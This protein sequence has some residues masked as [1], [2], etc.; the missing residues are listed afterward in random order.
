VTGP[1]SKADL[2]GITLGGHK[3]A[4]ASGRFAADKHST[5]LR[6]NLFVVV[7]TD[8]QTDRCHG[9]RHPDIHSPTE[10]QTDKQTDS[11]PNRQTDRCFDRWTDR[12]A[13]NLLFCLTEEETFLH[14]VYTSWTCNRWSATAA[15]ARTCCATGSASTKLAWCCWM[16]EVSSSAA[17]KAGCVVSRFRNSW[18]VGSPL[19][20]DT[21]CLS[22]S[23]A[24][25]ECET[26]SDTPD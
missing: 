19:T 9:A 10:P 7:R 2:A 17:M 26:G 5:W 8:R 20:C 3:Y 24:S 11:Q 25:C 15:R 13:D 6:R 18:L 22:D 14:K 12:R 16:K 23:S 4:S 21:C 1:A